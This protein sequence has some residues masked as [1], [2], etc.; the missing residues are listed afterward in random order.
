MKTPEAALEH[1]RETINSAEA[2][3]M[4]SAAV[5]IADLKVLLKMAESERAEK[6]FPLFASARPAPES[7]R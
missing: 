7:D 6:R 4:K 1:I 5:L 2:L 3:R